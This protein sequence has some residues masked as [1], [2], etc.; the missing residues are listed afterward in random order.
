MLNT[1]SSTSSCSMYSMSSSSIYYSIITS[2]IFTKYWRMSLITVLV[3]SQIFYNYTFKEPTFYE[4]RRRMFWMGLKDTYFF[5]YYKLTITLYVSSTWHYSFMLY[6][7][8]FKSLFSS[9]ILYT[10]PWITL[11]F[12]INMAYFSKMNILK[13]LT[14]SSLFF[15]FTKLMLRLFSM[16][17]NR[18]PPNLVL[19]NQYIE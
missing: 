3:E 8:P 5:I 12:S 10:V 7:N 4:L 6:I 18:L 16:K 11:A 9:S 17:S 1:F 14:Y 19:T 15:M 2:T 13:L